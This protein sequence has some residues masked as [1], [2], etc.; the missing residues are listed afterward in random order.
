M[1]SSATT[2][3]AYLAS[4][5]DD[6]RAAIEAVRQVILDN[7]D[8]GF[9]EGMQ[10]GM[11]GYYVPHRIYPKGYHCNPKQ[12]LP[13]AGLAS[14]KNHMSFYCFGIY[15]GPPDK[16]GETTTSLQFRN[17]WHAT[18]KK[19]DMGKCCV[20]FRK[21]EDVPLHVIGDAIR[22]LTL[23]LFIQYYESAF[24]KN[25]VRKTA[26]AKPAKTAAKKP[27]A[28]KTVAKKVRPKSKA[29]S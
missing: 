19:L 14:Q 11:I 27:A 18:G 3:S 13:F 22:R 8:D 7:L 20:R 4:L 28:K 5:P 12:P 17:E 6:R 15:C 25:E 29:K 1:Q 9:E 23:P 24:Q 10:Y 26:M 2:V 21:L 16:N